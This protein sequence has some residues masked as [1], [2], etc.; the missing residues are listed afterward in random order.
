M[1]GQEMSLVEYLMTSKADDESVQT[2]CVME[3]Q[4]D[5]LVP[6]VESHPVHRA[7]YYAIEYAILRSQL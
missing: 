7:G 5:V 1:D 6:R 2:S 3:R 4:I